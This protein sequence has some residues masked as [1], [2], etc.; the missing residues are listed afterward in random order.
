MATYFAL[1]YDANGVSR[2]VEKKDTSTRAITQRDF[3]F[4]SYVGNQITSPEDPNQPGDGNNTDDFI[5]QMGTGT[6]GNNDEMDSFQRFIDRSNLRGFMNEGKGPKDT[7]FINAVFA[8][9]GVPV[10]AEGLTKFFD[11]IQ[12]FLPKESPEVKRIR[13]FYATEGLKYMNPNSP[14]YIPGLENYNIVYGDPRDPDSGLQN[15][16]TKRM[17]TI[18]NTLSNASYMSKYGLD[19]GLTSREIQAIIDGTYAGP[20]TPLTKRYKNL[21]DVASLEFNFKY[22]D[23]AKT[24]KVDTVDFKD[25]PDFGSDPEGEFGTGSGSNVPPG[26][27]EDTEGGGE[28]STPQRQRDLSGSDKKDFGPYQDRAKAASETRSRDLGS[29]RGGVGRNNPGTSNQGFTDS[30]KFAGL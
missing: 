24:D 2:I 3:N 22:D 10:T 5:S 4:G 29:M 13:K 23:V 7:K 25:P 9:L 8:A 15:V 17:S 11:N 26:I 1:E 21:N 6:M 30:G 27:V 18:A 12:K 14:D 19:R 16:I 28:F 20:E